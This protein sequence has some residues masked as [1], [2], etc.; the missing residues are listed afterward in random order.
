MANEKLPV[1]WV[2]MDTKNK[3]LD[4]E[5]AEEV[6]AE[7]RRRTGWKVE[8]GTPIHRDLTKF[9]MG[10][11]KIKRHVAEVVAIF[12]IASKMSTE[13]LSEGE[14]EEEEAASPPPPPPP[15]ARKSCPAMVEYKAPRRGQKPLRKPTQI[16]TFS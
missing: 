8:Q 9:S 3:A 12:M 14:E 10:Y 16:I 5:Y 6:R 13:P 1:T 15:P 2:F 11:S 4:E 7:F